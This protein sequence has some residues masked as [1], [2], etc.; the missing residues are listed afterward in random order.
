MNRFLKSALVA[1]LL[2]LPFAAQADYEVGDVVAD[3]TLPNLAGEDVSL[4]D[5]SGKVVLVHFF[6]TW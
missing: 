5:F 2:C 6:A 1:M 4:F 3:F